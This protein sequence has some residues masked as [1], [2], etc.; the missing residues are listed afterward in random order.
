MSHVRLAAIDHNQLGWTDS[1]FLHALEHQTKVVRPVFGRNHQ[2]Q[3]IGELHSTNPRKT[4]GDAARSWDKNSLAHRLGH[5]AAELGTAHRSA[6]RSR[7]V[8]WT[9]L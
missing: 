6:P 3:A 9:G 2:R 8:Q 7:K 1:L 4:P 5:A